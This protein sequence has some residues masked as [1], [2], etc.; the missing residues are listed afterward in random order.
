MM[1]QKILDLIGRHFNDGTLICAAPDGQ[2]WHVGHGDPT[3]RILL[4]DESVLRRILLHPQLAFGETYM[5][6]GWEPENGDLRRVLEVA[7]RMLSAA[8]HEHPHGKLVQGGLVGLAKL[9]ELN[10][11]LRAKRNIH[12]HYDLD[13]ALYSRFLDRDLHYSCAYYT[14]PEMSLEEAQQAKCAHIADKLDLKPGARVLDIGCG[15]GSMAMYLAEHYDCRAT[16]ITLSV[17]QAKVARARA[18]ERGLSE[19]VEFR[20]VD[21]RNVHEKFDA[22]VSIGMFEH[23]GRPQ[24]RTYFRQIHD[25]LTEDGTALMHCIGRSTPPGG[26]SPWIEKYI[27]PGGYIPAASEVTA[28]LEPSGMILTDLE[29]LRLHYAYTLNNWAQRFA[30]SRGDIAERMGERFCRMWEFYLQACEMGFH[31]GDLICMQAQMTRRLERLPIT[32]D[33]LLR[34]PATRDA[35][36]TKA[37]VSRT[38][39]ATPR[40]TRAPRSTRTPHQDGDDHTTGSDSTGSTKQ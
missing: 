25:L 1:I 21:Y 37:P 39:S 32:R 24:Y 38:R 18:E 14:D 9:R 30:A 13:F 2:T 12:R 31:W 23:V 28:A 17:E 11:P 34:T 35:A 3:A 8:E 36:S 5:D 27:F 22:I 4:K 29:I 6:H 20:L 15:W 26:G 7:L 19:R 10:N 16:G 40:K 33:Y